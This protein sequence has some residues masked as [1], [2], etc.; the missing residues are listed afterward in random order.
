M[1]IVAFGEEPVFGHDFRPSTAA[2]AGLT[3]AAGW[4]QPAVRPSRN[5]APRQVRVVVDAFG[6]MV[7]S[8]EGVLWSSLQVRTGRKIVTRRKAETE[9]SRFPATFLQG[10]G[11]R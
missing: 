10:G 1:R 3:L 5:A 9:K 11:N 8:L 6:R 7:V 4:V 2:I